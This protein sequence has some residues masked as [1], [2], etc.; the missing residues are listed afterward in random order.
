MDEKL[1]LFL[2][3]LEYKE[4]TDVLKELY[5]N[6]YPDGLEGRLYEELLDEGFDVYYFPDPDDGPRVSRG[7]F[8][9]Y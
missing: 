5:D 4:E 8:G 1:D 2:K 9:F 6:P 7:P 3:L